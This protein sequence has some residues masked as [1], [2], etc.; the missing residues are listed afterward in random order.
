MKR[1]ILF[2][3]TLFASL[4]TFATGQEG[5]YIYIDGTKWNLLGKPI[6]GDSILSK[7]LEASLP[8]ERPI[9]TSNW[10]GY[11]AYWS[12]VKDK[13]CLDSICC[14]IDAAGSE[15][16]IT[17]SL[18]PDTLHRIFCK[19]LNG[20]R[21][22]ATWYNKNIRVVRGHK[23]Y[24]EHMGYERYHEEEQLISLSK[25]KVTDVKVF[26]NH[27][28]DGLSFDH[29][30]PSINIQEPG[31]LNKLFPLHPER[32]SDLEGVK[33]VRFTVKDAVV[34]TTGHMVKCNIEATITR[35]GQ[36]ESH[37]AIAAEME[38]LMKAYYPWR[39]YF[40]N[41]EYSSHIKGSRL[42][43]RLD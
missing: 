25:G 42:V 34:D 36:K 5:D 31:A 14:E 3:L 11:T 26:H 7:A 37:P 35:N 16:E 39:V 40:I 12:I 2:I 4:A 30:R 41:G 38:E 27:M 9:I 19:Y 13:L 18:S 1:H 32:Y 23:V 6:Y 17:V 10:S 15:K 28:T 29:F 33:M 20:K 43:Y 22:V 21:I 24:Y 8:K